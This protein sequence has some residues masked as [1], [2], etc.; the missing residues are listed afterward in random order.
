MREW[1]EYSHNRGILVEELYKRPNWKNLIQHSNTPELRK[2][3]LAMT[4]TELAEILVKLDH[5]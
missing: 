3:L 1:L 5:M 4:P 2:K